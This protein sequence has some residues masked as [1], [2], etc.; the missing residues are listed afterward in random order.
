ML[1]HISLNYRIA[2]QIFASSYQPQTTRHQQPNKEHAKVSCAKSN[3]K[4]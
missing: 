4:L 1:R 3:E 2:V